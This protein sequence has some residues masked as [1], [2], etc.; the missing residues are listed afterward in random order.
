MGPIIKI[1][2]NSQTRPFSGLQTLVVPPALAEH[3]MG[4]YLG[5]RLG[6]QPELDLTIHRKGM[7]ITQESIPEIINPLLRRLIPAHAAGV[8]LEG[9][10][11]VDEHSSLGSDVSVSSTD[12]HTTLFYGAQL[13]G[14]IT[15]SN[16]ILNSVILS[17]DGECGVERLLADQQKQMPKITGDE[18]LPPP[19]YFIVR[20]LPPAEIKN[21][22]SVKQSRV[23]HSFIAGPV[24]ISGQSEIINSYIDFI[25][26][27]GKIEIKH[28]VIENAFIPPWFK[29]EPEGNRF[30]EKLN[31]LKQQ[32]K[33]WIDTIVQKKGQWVLEQMNSRLQA[34]DEHDAFNLAVAITL[35][36]SQGEDEY[37]K[38]VY[39]LF[40]KSPE[41]IKWLGRISLFS[42]VN[43]WFLPKIARIFG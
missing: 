38:R 41:L 33:K 28:M 37:V 39:P 31:D 42:D 25:G 3:L 11:E 34:M 40:P 29:L 10:I 8:K 4:K 12:Q 13:R 21:Q 26:A 1:V 17:P 6:E 27:E 15:V 22:I 35:L 14:N 36:N 23:E 30:R 9:T 43:E 2:T 18:S 7:L 16:A 20:R 19:Q 32:Q 24:N 5:K